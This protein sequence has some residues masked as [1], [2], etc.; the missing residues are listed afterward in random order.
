VQ[1]PGS[2]SVQFRVD[3]PFLADV[4]PRVGILACWAGGVPS[5]VGRVNIGS[6]A[7][8]NFGDLGHYRRDATVAL[9]PRSR[10]QA[11][12]LVDCQPTWRAVSPPSAVIGK[13]DVMLET[14]A[15]TVLIACF[16]DHSADVPC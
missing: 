1:L 3:K 16:L 11:S 2:G 14:P 6:F 9:K 13:A 4:S 10:L 8:A 12:E 7:T 5:G 15:M